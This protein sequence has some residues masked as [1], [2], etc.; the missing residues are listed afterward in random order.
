VG[1][2]DEVADDRVDRRL[3]LEE[4]HGVAA[5]WTTPCDPLFVALDV[6]EDVSVEDA[7]LH[8]GWRWHRDP[9]MQDRAEQLIHDLDQVALTRHAT[10]QPLEKVPKQRELEQ[11]LG[12]AGWPAN[13]AIGDSEPI[14]SV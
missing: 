6:S 14:P 8:V 9:L 12:L 4:G 1:L 10:R 7:S 2:E 11:L 13:D 3:N 5:A